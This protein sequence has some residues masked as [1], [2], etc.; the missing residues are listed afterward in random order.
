MIGLGAFGRM[1]WG[2]LGGSTL[3]TG[4][5]TVEMGIVH[6]AVAVGIVAPTVDVGIA[7]PAV[8]VGVC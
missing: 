8:K 4:A 3:A 6:P 5:G 1:L 2:W 7:F